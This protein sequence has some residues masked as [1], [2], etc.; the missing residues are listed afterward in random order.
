MYQ[1]LRH[2][3]YSEVSPIYSSLHILWQ[4]DSEEMITL[5]ILLFVSFSSSSHSVWYLLLPNYSVRNIDG[6]HTWSE[7]H[8]H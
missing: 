6:H 4:K 7:E 2:I 8:F 3:M 1:E 5:D